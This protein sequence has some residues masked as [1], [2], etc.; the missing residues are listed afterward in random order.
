MTQHTMEYVQWLVLAGFLGN[1][2]LNRPKALN[3]AET[4]TDKRR[5]QRKS[6]KRYCDSKDYI[7]PSSIKTG[8]S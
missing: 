4:K 7:E 1:D 2:I 8:S 3:I 6:S 5:T